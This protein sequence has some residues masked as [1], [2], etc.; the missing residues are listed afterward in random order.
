M[1]VCLSV[2][3]FPD[4]HQSFMWVTDRKV[5]GVPANFLKVLDTKG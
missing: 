1:F 4:M 5:L 3:T 2:G